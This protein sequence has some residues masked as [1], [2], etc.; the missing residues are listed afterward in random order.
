MRKVLLSCILA[1]SVY[2]SQY[3]NLSVQ[4]K[5][6][7]DQDISAISC[8]NNSLCLIASDETSQLQLV[9][10]QGDNLV[11]RKNISLGKFKKENDIEGLTNDGK[12]FYAVGS[13]GLSRKKGKYQKSR[14]Q[15]FKISIDSSDDIISLQKS[16]LETIL[17]KTKQLR[18]YFKKS[19]EKN[20]VNIEGL[21]YSNGKLF[22]GFRGPIIRGNAQIL[23]FDSK[24]FW[25]KA[26]SEI[27]VFSVD[28][29]N[30][31][32][33]RSLEIKDESFYIVAGNNDKQKNQISELVISDSSLQRL[34]FSAVPYDHLKLEGFDL[35]KKFK[36]FVYDSQDNGLPVIERF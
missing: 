22:L 16:N 5:I 4:G 20:G 2:A 3:L 14:Y 12:S 17:M 18:P 10:I 6:L 27:E 7:G 28:L 35:N 11:V 25:D 21:A 13:H 9:K 23:S 19:L 33:I 15:I 34:F 31:R 32:G 1:T 26:E 29:G 24:D 36:V 8:I 30:E